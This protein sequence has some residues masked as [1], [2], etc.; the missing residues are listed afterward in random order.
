MQDLYFD[1][2]AVFSSQLLPS[3]SEPQLALVVLSPTTYNSFITRENW[4]DLKPLKR[5]LCMQCSSIS[6]QF[7]DQS[8]HNIQTFL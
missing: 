3:V 5:K 1:F 7:Q 2:L 4:F 8:F 6:S